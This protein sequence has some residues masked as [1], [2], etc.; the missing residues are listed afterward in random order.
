[1]S[2]NR[3]PTVP[4]SESLLSSPL[5]TRIDLRT[6]LETL[7][8]LIFDATSLDES[9]FWHCEIV[10]RIDLEIIALLISDD[11]RDQTS[12]PVLRQLQAAHVKTIRNLRRLIG[13]GAG[14]SWP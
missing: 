11:E 13:R 2:G 1:M 8:D 3:K 5:R 4:K 10:E 6:E 7:A 9:L 14:L 12:I